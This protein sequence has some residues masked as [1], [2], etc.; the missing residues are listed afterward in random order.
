MERDGNRQQDPPRKDPI[1]DLLAERME[2]DD[3]PEKLLRRPRRPSA[4]KIAALGLA[5][6]I[7]S[8]ALVLGLGREGRRMWPASEV[9]GQRAAGL[10]DEDAVTAVGHVALVSGQAFLVREE[11][12][13]P[14]IEGEDVRPGDA[15]ETPGSGAAGITC[16]SGPA[17][18]VQD[19]AR[20]VLAGRSEHGMHV[21]LDRGE[22]AAHVPAG[23]GTGLRVS[24]GNAEV[25]VRGT[26]FTVRAEAGQITRATVVQGEIDV[27]RTGSREATRVSRSQS[28][29]LGSWTVAE[30]G[31][32]PSALAHLETIADFSLTPVVEDPAT[33]EAAGAERS[34]TERIRQALDDGD[35]DRA[36]ALVE[37]HG[38]ATGT[39]D[40]LLAAAETY[41]RAGRF[42]EAAALFLDVAATSQGRK[43]EKALIRAAELHLRKLG[44]PARA[45]EIAESYL[46]RFP[47]GHHLADAF[48]LGGIA[49][50]KSGKPARGRTLLESYLAAFPQGAEATRVH[51]ALARILVLDVKNCA[52]AASHI[53][54]VRARAAGT[55]LA[56]QADKLASICLQG[57]KAQP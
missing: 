24:A 39:T 10:A 13:R 2:R 32:E 5:L 25:R 29:D 33:P 1:W 34:L 54:A 18:V 46:A 37:G 57:G 16:F 12:R 52:A 8:A 17:L 48:Y 6:V 35:I 44:D 53:E 23:T 40:F 31:V 9:D 22:L 55:P 11:T 50:I 38:T 49:C 51:L 7:V 45:A 30:G 4:P 36:L 28:L 43:A 3:V 42:E 27:V 26:L 21:E 47:Q 41:R 20:L 14:L 19:G 56:V 15:V